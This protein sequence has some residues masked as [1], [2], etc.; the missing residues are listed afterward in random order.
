M[1]EENR[2]KERKFKTAEE[3]ENKF[4]EYIE[5]CKKENKLANVAGFCVFADIGRHTFYDQEQFYPHTYKKINN[6]LEDAT[7]NAKINDTFKIFYMKNKFDYRDKQ[8][9]DANV[10]TD[11]KVTL[12]D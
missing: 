10:N 4:I 2:G 11:I 6:I 5:D 12:D 7:I 1:E 9:I 3:F 8:D